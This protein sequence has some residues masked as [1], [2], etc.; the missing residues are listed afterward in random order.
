[1]PPIRPDLTTSHP[2]MLEAV[3]DGAGVDAELGSNGCKRQACFVEL[4]GSLDVVCELAPSGGDAFA[5]EDDGDGLV[6]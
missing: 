2:E 5:L 4:D 3:E 1:M 6:G